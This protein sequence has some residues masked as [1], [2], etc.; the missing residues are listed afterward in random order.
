MT[1]GKILGW[2]KQEGDAVSTGTEIVEIETSKITNVMEAGETGTMRRIVAEAGAT[3]P[4]GAL[5]AVVALP[6]VH[7]RRDRRL[8]RRVR[9]PRRRGRSRGRRPGAAIRRGRRAAAAL[10]R[11]RRR[12]RP[13]R[14]D[15]WLWRR[16]QHLDVRAAGAGRAAPHG[17]ARSARARRVGE[18]GRRRRHRDAGRRGWRRARR[19]RRREPAP[20]RAFARR[21]RRRLR[22]P[23]HGRSPASRCSPRPGSAPRST[24]SS[25]ASATSRCSGGA[26]RSRY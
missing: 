22:S 24:A 23:G 6:E 7:R 25:S 21:R 16:P 17:L 14:V 11:T 3:L 1:E 19:A 18:G 10:S 13:D 2:L 9:S 4:I 26:R 15:P 20:G 8:C 12:R 5:I